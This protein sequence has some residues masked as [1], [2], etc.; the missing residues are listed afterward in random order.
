[1]KVQLPIKIMPLGNSITQLDWQGG[2]RRLLKDSLVLGGFSTDFV[3]SNDYGQANWDNPDYEHEGY[4]SATITREAGRVYPQIE[5]AA[6]RMATYQPEIV[7]IELGTN[8][9]HSGGRTPAMFRDDMRMLLDTIWSVNPGIKI[10]LNTIT[11][12]DTIGHSNFVP[13][14]FNVIAANALFPALVSEKVVQGRTIVLADVY[15]AF[16]P[17]ESVKAYILDGIHPSYDG[18]DG[19]PVGGYRRMAKAIY[20]SVKA[21]IDGLPILPFAPILLSP[22]NAST[23]HDTI[24]SLSWS[25]SNNANKYRLQ[26]STDSGFISIVHDDTTIPTISKQVNGLNDQKY[27]WRV[28]A[29]N[30]AGWGEWSGTWSF[31]YLN[32]VSVSFFDDLPGQFILYNNYPN[33]FNPETNIEYRISDNGF[34]T[35][36]IFNMVGQEVA[37]LVKEVQQP[38]SYRVNWDARCLP[39]GVYYCRLIAGRYLSAINLLLLK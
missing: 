12:P 29:G 23:N 38:G 28:K 31:M 2:Y 1:M 16:M 30:S 17:P 14:W 27:Y 26:L 24:L 25:S 4:N 13:L 20:P 3:G 18:W 36:N 11:P 35:L 22:L 33:P 37:V 32:P 7:I 21:L 10:V 39:S 8:D 19:H 6:E 9:L 15:A 5:T 34:V